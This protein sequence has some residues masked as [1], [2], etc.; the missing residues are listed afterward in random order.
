MHLFSYWTGPITWMER[1][2]VASA[3]ATG[4]SLTIFTHDVSAIGGLGLGCGVIHAA[5]ILN[6]DPE[7]DRLR[8]IHAAHYADHFRAEGIATGVGTWVDLDVVF[9]KT[10]PDDAH[11]FGWENADSINGAVLRLPRGPLLSDY[12]AVL[13][14]RP[15]P[16]NV[17][18]LPLRTRVRRQVKR[19][20][21][22]LQ[23]RRPP[24]PVLGPATLTHLIRKHKLEGAAQPQ[25]VFY[26]IAPS[27]D[28][29]QRLVE[30]G[31]IEKLIAPS[32]I[33][34]HLSGSYFRKIHG[35]DA[36]TTGWLK[37]QMTAMG[38]RAD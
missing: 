18:W 21:R 15:M 11:L 31:F 9:L 26:A 6:D 25:E 22:A 3:L 7:L 30:E 38:L 2:S 29:L 5:E 28:V 16:Y 37:K 32:T 35:L 24:A 10:L 33:A 8:A 14:K 1:L 20:T 27:K 13:R 23:G 4:H 12:L 36:P 19:V 34:L 17:P